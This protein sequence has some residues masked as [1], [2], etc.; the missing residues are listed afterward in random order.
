MRLKIGVSSKS[1]KQVDFSNCDDFFEC[2][3]C[4][5]FGGAIMHGNNAFVKALIRKR[6]FNNFKPKVQNQVFEEPAKCEQSLIT[7]NAV[8]AAN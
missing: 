8:N 1:L 2:P 6:N 7:V 4:G 3:D 5:Y